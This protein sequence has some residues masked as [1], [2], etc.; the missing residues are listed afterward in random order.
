[1]K[2]TPVAKDSLYEYLMQAIRSPDRFEFG[3]EVMGNVEGRARP[4]FAKNLNEIAEMAGI[5]ERVRTIKEIGLPK[6][7]AKATQTEDFLLTLNR[8]FEKV[9][10]EPELVRKIVPQKWVEHEQ[11]SLIE[12][13]R[14]MEQEYYGMAQPLEINQE[15]VITWGQGNIDFLQR[16]DM[17]DQLVKFGSTLVKDMEDVWRIIFLAQ[18]SVLSPAIVQG[19]KE[20]RPTINILMVGE[21]STS[22]SSLSYYMRKMFPRVN[23]CNET[24]GVGLTGTVDRKGNKVM[25]LAEESDRAILVLEEFDKLFRNNGKLDGILRAILEDGEYH[26]RL[27]YGRLDYETRPSVFAMANPKRDVFFSNENLASQVP[28]K[29]GLLSR[30]DY[31]RPIAYSS[32]KINAIA[33]FIAKTA[34]RSNQV[35]GMMTTKEVRQT[36]YAMQSSL[37]DLK[38][39]QVASEESLLMEIWERFQSL[40]KEIEDVPLLSVR[41][42][43]SALRVYNASAIMHHKA[44]K[45]VDG[46]VHANEQ[47]RNNSIFILDMNAKMR[48]TLL[49][50]RH[51]ND[52]CLSPLD[53]A[54]GHLK[55]ALNRGP[56]SKE[57]AVEML[58]SSMSIG[59]STAYKYLHAIVE[60]DGTIRQEGLRDAKLVLAE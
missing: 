6:G 8:L 37:N 24:T 5:P 4:A 48:E 25:G 38:V 26:R 33:G 2:G 13:Y 43:M 57:D 56:L 21:Y 30:F 31:V 35:E 39:H 16:D 59:K 60:R 12:K 20:H 32:S 23:I 9:R 42:F 44:R 1:M 19:E 51:R 34:F 58:V 52:V 3:D 11:E 15:S 36:F 18:A 45:V 7:Q 28:F 40:Q 55:T 49:T 29:V 14:S 54:N 47:D 27:A 17:L 10:G 53:K 46:I 22:K 41:D 50:S